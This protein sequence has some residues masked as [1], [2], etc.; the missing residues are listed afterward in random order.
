MNLKIKYSVTKH[1]L[2]FI[3]FFFTWHLHSYAIDNEYL[4]ELIDKSKQEKIY[5]SREWK[6]LLFFPDRFMNLK[7]SSLFSENKFFLAHDGKFNSRNELIETL[8]SFFQPLPKVIEK[9][10]VHSQ[11]KYAGR[12][13]FLNKKLN[14][15]FNRFPKQECPDLDKFISNADYTSVSLV[16]SNYVADGPGSLFGHTFLRLQRN[17]SENNQTDLLDDIINFSAFVPSERDFLFAIKGLAGG[18]KGRFSLLP[19]YQ[20]IQEYNNFESRDLWEYKLNFSKDEID[21]LKRIIWEIGWT[22]IDYFYL[23]DNCAYVILSLIEAVKPNLHLTEKILIYAIPSDTIRIVNNVPNFVEEI[24]YR[25]S[26]LSRYLNRFENLNKDEINVFSEVINNKN[27]KLPDS[28]MSLEKISKAKTIDT[29]LEYIDYKEKL[30]GSLEPEKYKELRSKILLVRANDL[31]KLDNIHEE[32]HSSPPHLGHDSALLSMSLGYQ[33]NEFAFSDFRI[34]PALHDIEGNE[35]GYSNGLGIGFLDTKFRLEYRNQNLYL[36]KFH[37][38]E[39]MSLPEKVP[40]LNFLAWHF[41]SGYEYGYAFGNSATQGREYLKAGVGSSIIDVKNN[42][43]L[44]F[45]IH[46]DSGYSDNFYWH[47]GPSVLIGAMLKL[48]DSIKILSKSEF[49]RR[50]NKDTSIDSIENTITLAYYMKQNFSLQL[51]YSYKNSLNEVAFTIQ[52]YF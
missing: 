24:Q 39:I 15:D 30:V 22:Y 43:L 32:I 9:D 38:L 18:Y 8:K 19:Y 36:N 23:D 47:I 5:E 41:D 29:I 52:N 16:F 51:N 26:V 2:F 34:R 17:F 44:Y 14:F 37:L 6:K 40:Y 45:I 50:F 33:L 11:C 1:F 10:Y 42:A 3:Q 25:P 20:K 31:I 49:A 4:Q 35:N 21:Y 48:N 46:A 27:N 12:F 7:N 28:I 13:Y